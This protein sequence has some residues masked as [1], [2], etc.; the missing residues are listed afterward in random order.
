MPK[1]EH[2][3]RSGKAASDDCTIPGPVPVALVDQVV[4]NR[5]EHQADEIREYILH[6]TN[7]EVVVHLERLV[8]E[9]VF[10]R[11]IEGWDVWTDTERYWV[12]TNPTNLYSQ[13]LFPSLDY[14]ITFHVGLTVRMT[15]I[16]ARRAST[17]QRDRLAVAWRK[18]EQAAD[19]FGLAN[20][21]EEFQVVG[22]RCRESLIA[23][24]RDISNDSMVPDG[25]DIPKAADF[26]L[27]SDLIANTIARGS[28]SEYVRGYLKACA[29]ST[30]K[31]ANWLTHATSAVRFDGRMTLDATQ[32]ILA[33]FGIALLRY[34]RDA[35][36]Q[37]PKCASYRMDT[38]YRPELDPEREYFALC[39]SCGWNDLPKAT[40]RSARRRSSV[41][42]K[43]V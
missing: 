3:K 24:A 23:M 4:L 8:T 6:A 38:V 31:M 25:Q 41:T 5:P 18:W 17:E 2:S 7:G 16:E 30:W 14:T 21:A 20:E 34:E 11:Q 28:G 36:E 42:K 39:E 37:C 1:G 19:A 35:P 32:S 15:G 43:R 29:K 22:M 12:V 10:D 40:V 27:W 26:V 33:A 9:H 13:T